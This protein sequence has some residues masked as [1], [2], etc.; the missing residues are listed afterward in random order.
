MSVCHVQFECHGQFDGDGLAN[1]LLLI[2][3]NPT[4]TRLRC[5]VILIIKKH[6]DYH[7]H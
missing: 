7:R 4:E 1:V 6:F 5:F 2:M 3:C